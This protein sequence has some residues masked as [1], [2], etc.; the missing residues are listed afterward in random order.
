MLRHRVRWA[1]YGIIS[2]YTVLA[3]NEK[4]LPFLGLAFGKTKFWHFLSLK[5]YNHTDE[6]QQG[7]AQ[8]ASELLHRNCSYP[9]FHRV[10]VVMLCDD[11]NCFYL[12]QN[13]NLTEVK[14]RPYIKQ[15]CCFYVEVMIC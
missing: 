2:I 9:Q 3:S 14:M 11:L 10:T 7:F 5:K 6:A 1:T 13:S 8:I 12:Y 4:K 15:L